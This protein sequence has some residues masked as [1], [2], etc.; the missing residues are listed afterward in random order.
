MKNKEALHGLDINEESFF[1]F[2]ILK[3]HE[4][5]FQNNPTV[6]LINP[7]KNQIG[8]IRKVILG[9]VNS[10]L[11]KQLKANQWKN[12]QNLIEWIMKIEEK[13]KYK[14]I[15]FDIKDFYPSIKETVFIKPIN[16]AERLVNRTNKGKVI[17]KRA[18]KSV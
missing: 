3:D 11:I 1:F 14:F 12:T 6:R 9:K 18:M 8:R 15:V 16:F 7:A 10:S 17:I 2:F 13:S 5:Y 4:E